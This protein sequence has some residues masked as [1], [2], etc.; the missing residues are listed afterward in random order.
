MASWLDVAALHLFHQVIAAAH[1]E[2]HDRQRR[3]LAG[4][5]TRTTRRPSR[6]DCR[7][8]ASAGTRSAPTSWDRGPCARCPSRGCRTRGCD[9]ARVNGWMF[10]A[11]A[12]SSICVAVTAMSGIIAFSFSPHVIVMRS[13]GM[14]NLSTTLG[15]IATK[16]SKR[17]STSPNPDQVDRGQRIEDALLERRAV[18]GR[19]HAEGR[20]AAALKAEAAQVILLA[21]PVDRVLHPDRVEPV[22]TPRRAERRPGRGRV[23]KLAARAAGDPRVIHQVVPEHAARVGEAALGSELKRMRADSSACAQSS[24]ARARTSRTSRV[25]RSMYITPVA[26]CVDGSVRTR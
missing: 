17:G 16:L 23:R 25:T 4:R 14:P 26:L 22:R 20:R 1:G 21:R 24:T 5:P 9:R 19:V 18:A 13:T 10:L 8:R 2:R 3:I 6:R 12:A 11:P 7:C 15:S